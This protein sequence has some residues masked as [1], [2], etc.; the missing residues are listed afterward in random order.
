MLINRITIVITAIVT[1]IVLTIF[2]TTLI[3]KLN[4]KINNCQQ[5]L[6][7]VTLINNNLQTS[8]DELDRYYK[9]L[10]KSKTDSFQESLNQCLKS[11]EKVKTVIKYKI[12]KVPIEKTIT[13]KELEPC[14]IK[15]IKDVKDDPVYHYLKRIGKYEKNSYTN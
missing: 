5:K 3:W 9:N 7:E 4:K 13:I 6:N 11:K 2:F 15:I 12:K 1:T 14:N 8:L 10:L